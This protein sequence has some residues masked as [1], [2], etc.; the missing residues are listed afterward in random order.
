MTYF[1]T[2]GVT[3]SSG[4]VV[5]LGDQPLGAPAHGAGEMEIGGRRAPSRQDEGSQRLELVIEPVDLGLEPIDLRRGDREPRAARP[6]ALAGRGEIGADVEQVVLD[7]RQRRVE[8]GILRGMQPGDADHGIR[9]IERAVGGDAQIVFLAPLAGA[10]RGR[11]VIAGAGVDLVED[12]HA[13]SLAP[14]A[15]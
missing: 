1:S 11:A 3:L 14:S 4:L 7:A 8:R 2:S 15:P 5:E 9:L 6:L 10:E 13:C 12:D